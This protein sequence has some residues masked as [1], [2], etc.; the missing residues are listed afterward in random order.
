M[1]EKTV[2]S[3]LQYSSVLPPTQ[4]IYNIPEKAKKYA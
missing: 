4:Q 1:I 2:E 3:Q